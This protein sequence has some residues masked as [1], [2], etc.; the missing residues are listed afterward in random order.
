MNHT[1]VRW[2]ALRNT[3]AKTIVTQLVFTDRP[4]MTRI[5]VNGEER[6]LPGPVTVVRLL[7][8]LGLADARVAVAVNR[9]IIPRS[10]HCEHQLRDEDQVEIVRAIGGGCG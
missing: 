3:I 5:F 2:A 10:R 8:E 7:Q 6:P 9:E 1:R 4:D